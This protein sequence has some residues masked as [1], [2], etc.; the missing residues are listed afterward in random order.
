MTTVQQTSIPTK[1]WTA[2]A[3]SDDG[4]YIVACPSGDYLRLGTLVQNGVYSWVIIGPQDSTKSWSSVVCDTTCSTIIACA[5]YSGVYKLTLNSS[6]TFDYV[7][8]YTDTQQDWVSICASLDFTKFV[9]SANGGYAHYSLDS[10]NTWSTI[11]V[12]Y[13]PLSSVNCNDDFSII[14]LAEHNGHT[15]GKA[16]MTK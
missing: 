6:G 16:H 14:L 7:N 9:I 2:A 1:P 15:V 3:I 11:G 12:V 8:V 10:G 4:Q 5:S 13:G